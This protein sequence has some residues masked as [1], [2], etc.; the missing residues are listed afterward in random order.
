MAGRHQHQQ[1]RDT[2]Q[3]HI[4]DPLAKE[5]KMRRRTPIAPRRMKRKPRRIGLREK[6]GIGTSHG[7]GL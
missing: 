2:P 6:A 7:S 5:E 4:H 1:P 3:R